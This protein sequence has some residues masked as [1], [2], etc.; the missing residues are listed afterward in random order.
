MRHRGE[1]VVPARREGCS[2]SSTRAS[3]A[4]AMFAANAS[5]DQ[6]LF[7]S[8]MS[9]PS[10]RP[11]GRRET[12]RSPP[13]PTFTLRSGHPAT[14]A[15]AAAMA[16]GEPRL[17][18]YAVSSGRSSA[19][20]AVLAADVSESFASRSHIAQSR[21]FRAAPA[22]MRSRKACRSIPS[23]RAP[24]MARIVSATPPTVSP[25]A[26]IGHRFTATGEAA[27]ADGRDHHDGFGLDAT[28]DGEAAGDRPP[29]D[30]QLQ[31]SRQSCP[32]FSPV[33]GGSASG[34][35][36]IPRHS[37]RP[38]VTMPNP[39]ATI[40]ASSGMNRSPDAKRL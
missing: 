10:G 33:P 3:D 25:I 1:Q 40:V 7:A 23:A 13:P 37:Q 17:M 26:G 20:P 4:A 14:A 30:R 6:D 28:G 21:A 11:R 27:F 32:V 38:M 31:A 12:R 15:A 18:V 39:A 9:G 16:S 24:A 34:V 19:N 5:A 36:P 35:T 29:F 8:I 22:G 2:I